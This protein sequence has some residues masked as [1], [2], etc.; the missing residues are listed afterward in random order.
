M[1]ALNLD[2][3]KITGALPG[4]WGQSFQQVTFISLAYCDLQS[5]L[6]SGEVGPLPSAEQQMHHHAFETSLFVT[7][8]A[9]G[10]CSKCLLV[11]ACLADL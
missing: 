10:S 11:N 1:Y 9:H 8:R 4:S 5:M 6:P 3:T 2:G 7:I